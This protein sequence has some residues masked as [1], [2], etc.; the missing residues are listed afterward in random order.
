MAI[1]WKILIPV[2]I[3]WIMLI[4]TV[5]AWRLD[6]SNTIPYVVGGVTLVVIVALV[7][8]WDSA[9]QQRAARYATPA[10]ADDQPGQAGPAPAAA[11]ASSFPVPPMD[12]PH[13][14]GI[15]ID[16][17]ASTREVTGA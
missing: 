9:A 7:W 1:G 4:A 2:S 15:G 6:T 12:L 17:E 8:M 14:H 3:V 11:S 13:Y 16:R 10:E 5:R